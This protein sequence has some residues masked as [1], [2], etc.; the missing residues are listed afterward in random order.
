MKTVSFCAKLWIKYIFKL[1]VVNKR[2]S[3][4]SPY[5]L[6]EF[7]LSTR[8]GWV[9][10]A[11][12]THFTPGNDLVL[13]VQGAGW[14]LGWSGQV[15]KILPPPAFDPWTV[16]PVQGSNPGGKNNVAEFVTQKSITKCSHIETLINT[17]GLLV[18]SLTVSSCT[19]L[20]AGNS[21]QVCLIPTSAE[22]LPT[23][24]YLQILGRNFH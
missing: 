20:Y 13:T 22:E 19:F 6:H 10:K 12:P 24:W 15:C 14:T 18:G 23:V 3:K 16:Q 9:T 5:N 8:W 7:N 2:K 4:I 1:T 11:C 21:I 17:C